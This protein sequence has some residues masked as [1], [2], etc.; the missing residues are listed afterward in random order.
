MNQMNQ[1]LGIQEVIGD[2]RDDLLRLAAE[3]G[4]SDVRI[5]G[6]VARGEADENSDI[7]ILVGF[8]VNKSIFDLVG[9]WLD[10]TELVGRD[11]SLLTDDS[12]EGDF[13]ANIERDAVR[14]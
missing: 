3:H 8:P 7:D 2:K 1:K 4:A 11:V 12:V 6:S 10:L 13:K 14:L 5:L 9:L